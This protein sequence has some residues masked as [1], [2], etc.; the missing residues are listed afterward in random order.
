MRPFAWQV[1]VFEKW[2]EN[3][4][5]G[6]VVA[7]P[8]AGK[9]YA[10]LQ[11]LS[12]FDDHSKT[13]ILVPT[14]PLKEQW[15]E[16][17][18]IQV[19]NVQSPDLPDSVDILVVDECHRFVTE[20]RIALLR[21]LKPKMVLGLTATPSKKV[22]EEFGPAI[23]DVGFDE[24]NVAD[25][26][27]HFSA[28]DM[29]A[30]EQVHYKKLTNM[31]SDI[32]KDDGLPIYE[33]EEKVK[34]LI[35]ERRQL[36]YKMKNRLPAAVIMVNKWLDDGRKVLVVAR[37]IEEGRVLAK[38]VRRGSLVYN[39]KDNDLAILNKFKEMEYGVLIS[40]QNL[41]EGFDCPDIDTLLMMSISIT[42]ASHIQTL[43]RAI[44][45][46]PDKDKVEV[47]VLV[48]R[49]TSDERVLAF[50]QEYDSV[51][52]PR[53]TVPLPKNAIKEQYYKGK[54][55]SLDSD[56]RV[57][58]KVK[59]N[60]VYMKQTDDARELAK[61]VRVRKRLGGKFSIYNGKVIVRD[62]EEYTLLGTWD[63]EL[64]EEEP[65]QDGPVTWES[66]FK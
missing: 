6:V 10:A 58:I 5:S 13:L 66:L 51:I 22:H 28:V 15:E 41:S 55:Y 42:H 44:R 63:G 43:G 40:C 53:L 23:T 56:G 27:V 64:V 35:M 38:A 45:K 50:A 21:A 33:L 57:F 18:D 8:G 39:S 54:R 46:C 52:D 12:N 11:A 49:S 36:V 3:D 4:F 60:R 25:F 37:T 32:M 29:T 47:H 61:M 19:L 1:D 9:S 59:W 7:V 17:T 34:W 16:Q 65:R 2:A 31:I 26:K 48:G 30:R 14:V 20:K 24:A 62:G